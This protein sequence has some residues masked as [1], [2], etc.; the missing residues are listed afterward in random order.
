MWDSSEGGSRKW[1]NC[2]LPNYPCKSGSRPL[3]SN[4]LGRGVGSNL[5]IFLGGT[6][7]ELQEGTAATNPNAKNQKIEVLGGGVMGE[8]ALPGSLAAGWPR[9]QIDV[10]ERR[11]EGAQRMT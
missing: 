7:S 9:E 1:L 3:A 6:M 11:D 10:S 8:T 4:W 5:V 2:S